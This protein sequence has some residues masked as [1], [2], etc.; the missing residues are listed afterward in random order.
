M[1]PEGADTPETTPEG[2]TLYKLKD[3]GTR[4][5]VGVLEN[6]LL[7]KDFEFRDLDYP[8]EKALGTYR[9]D[10]EDK[11]YQ[12][13]VTK[14]LALTLTKLG[15]SPFNHQPDDEKE[16]E[17]KALFAISKCPMADVLYMYICCRVRELGSKLV[18]PFAHGCGFTG[19]VEYDLNDLDVLV[20]DDPALLMKEVELVHGMRWR[21]GSVKKKVY[22]KPM[23]WFHM[24]SEE[25]RIAQGNSILL[26]LHMLRYST[27]VEVVGKEG[28]TFYV[29]PEETELSSLRKID[30]VKITGR[31][32]DLNLGAR[33]IS[34]GKCKKCKQDYLQ[35][36]DATYENFFAASSLS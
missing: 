6:A 16:A 28:E 5:P 9:A 11:P 14:L 4:M 8:L 3:L 15:G 20:C 1:I 18:Y 32:L 10:H 26:E 24:E 13:V 34:E 19:K 17:G 21:D 27:F 2:F 35:P 31:M 22:V 33:L 29:A 25:G 30:M 36:I 7:R 23:Q 12:V